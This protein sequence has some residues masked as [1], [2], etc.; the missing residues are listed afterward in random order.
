MFIH[1]VRDVFTHHLLLKDLRER[2]RIYVVITLLHIFF[3]VPFIAAF[4]WT[5]LTYTAENLAAHGCG[6]V[7]ISNCTGEDMK[8]F[9]VALT[10]IAIFRSL[11]LMAFAVILPWI[12][13][14]WSIIFGII[15][16]A[17]F[18]VA[19][20]ELITGLEDNVHGH[21]L[22]VLSLSFV[23]RFSLYYAFTSGKTTAGSDSGNHF[24][25]SSVLSASLSY[26]VFSAVILVVVV[27]QIRDINWFSRPVFICA[28]L[29]LLSVPDMIIAHYNVLWFQAL[30]WAK[31]QL[32]AQDLLV[33][34]R[35]DDAGATEHLN[36]SQA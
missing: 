33:A 31:A 24:H 9:A 12:V 6:L 28:Q 11:S 4:S 26:L 16:L 29:L 10:S 2:G 19:M 35:D 20:L 3:V 14:F 27:I 25:W 5:A 7:S 15:S 18:V 30:C 23:F 21:L 34:A 32:A 22:L 1:T 8:H 13:G 17:L 36:E